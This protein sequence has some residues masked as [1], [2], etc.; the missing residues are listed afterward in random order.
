MAGSSQINSS[1]HVLLDTEPDVQCLICTRPFTLDTEVNDSFEAL[2]I[3]RECKTIVLNENDNNRYEITSTYRERRRRRP[4]SRAT[5]LESFEAAFSQGLSH[6]ANLARQGHEADIDSPPLSHRQASFTSTPNRSRRWHASDDESDGLN[7]ADSV[8]GETESNLSFGENDGGSDVSLDQHARM[9]REIAIQLDS[10][11]YLNTDTDIDP[12]NASGIDLWDSDGQE[13]VESEESDFDE[14]V[15]TMQQRQQRRHSI[16]PGGFDEHESEDVAW[17]LATAIPRTVGMINLRAGMEEPAI[18]RHFIGNP[19]D[20]VNARQFEMLLDQ[21]AEENNTRRGAPPAAKSIIE[22]LPSVVISI[23]HE[24]N[25][26]VTCPVCKDNMPAKTVTKQ[27]PCMHQYHSSCILPWLSYRNTC[28]VCRYE[29]PTDDLEYERLKHATAN[30]RGIHWLEHIHP[31]E[32]VEEISV[33]PEVEGA[34]NTRNGTTEEAN[35][36]GHSAHASQ[37]PDRARGHQRWLVIA[38][39]PVVSLVGLA[40]VL[41]FASSSS[42]ASR[43]LWRR[44]RSTTAS[45]VDTRR[46]WWSIF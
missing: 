27:L 38:A 18:R 31:Q 10:E 16:A 29:F 20:Y 8:F 22:N 23:S 13:D 43:Q 40:L 42:N 6:L 39:A 41:C 2:A 36:N 24:T 1:N 4:R 32:P 34:F 17:T 30:E 21:F 11:S 28:P 44:S 15:D 7:Y 19:G 37:R 25:G 3:C 5:S 9:G 12:M 45:H 46:S 14:V 33:G 35:T 26:G